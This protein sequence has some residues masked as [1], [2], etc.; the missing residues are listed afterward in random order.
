M[1]ETLSVQH[2]HCVQSNTVPE[3]FKKCVPPMFLVLFQWRENNNNLMT[4]ETLFLR[5]QGNLPKFFCEPKNIP[6]CTS[7]CL[8]IWNAMI[9]L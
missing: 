5:P 2:F 6:N 1:A 8:A 7:F 4:L 9:S 3:L